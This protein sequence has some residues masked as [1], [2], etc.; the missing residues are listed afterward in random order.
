MSHT[1]CTEYTSPRAP[2][3]LYTLPPFPPLAISPYKGE[4]T[5]YPPPGSWPSPSRHPTENK[6]SALIIMRIDGSAERWEKNAPKIPSCPIIRV[7]NITKKTPTRITDFHILLIFH[8]GIRKDRISN[9]KRPR[10]FAHPFFAIGPVKC[11][12]TP[13]WGKRRG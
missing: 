12:E 2:L 4:K 3:P 11:R 6:T 8:P 13:D 7:I 9:L 10:R 5:E 1:L